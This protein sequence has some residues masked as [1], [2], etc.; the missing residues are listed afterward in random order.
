[1]QRLSYATIKNDEA[2]AA[3]YDD[4]NSAQILQHC[5]QAM[6]ASI[7]DSL[8]AYHLI[9]DA[10]EI[11][12]FMAPIVE[13][14]VESCTAAPPPHDPAKKATQCEVCDRDWVPLTY[15]H[16]IPRQVHAKVL[17]RG[18]HEEWQLNSVAWLCRACHSFIHRITSNEELAKEWWSM[19]RILQREDVQ[20]WAAWVGRVRWKSR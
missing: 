10:E 18:W 3:K 4:G 16:L 13:G 20:S 2:L 1:M 9:S 17:K 11:P 12:N 6:P 19:E 5:V 8:V 7:G 14:Y 15:H